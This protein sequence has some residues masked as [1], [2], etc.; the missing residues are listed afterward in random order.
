MSAVVVIQEKDKIYFGADTAISI[1]INSETF[2]LNNNGQKLFI[3]E[4]LLIFCSGNM[5]L[6]KLIIKEF[7]NNTSHTI[8][9]LRNIAK[10]LYNI[11]PK[12]K[13]E[14]NLDIIAGEVINGKSVVYQISPYYN[15]EIMKKTVTDGIGLYTG[16]IKTEDSFNQMYLN[17]IN[18]RGLIESYQDTFNKISYEGIGGK[19]LLYKIDINGISKIYENKIQEKNIKYFSVYHPNQYLIVGERIFGKIIAGVNLTIENDSGKYRFDSSGFTIDGGSITIIGGL[20]P[21]QLDPA[22]K[23]SLVELN[24]DYSNGVRIDTVQGI[25]VTR[26]DDRVKSI[27]NATDGIKIQVKEGSNWTD[28]F[29]FDATTGNLNIDG[30][31]NAR[32]L[33]VNGQSV[34]TAD[35]L[36]INGGA[37]DKIKVEQL[38][39]STAKITTAM[40]E[41]LEV[42]R[43]VVMGANATISWSQVSNKPFIPQTA[44]DVGALP[45]NSPKL[46]YIDAYG[47]YTG[48][49]QANNIVGSVF[50]VGN[51]TGQSTKLELWTGDNN[52]HYIKSTQAA[53]FR[54]EST[55]SLSLQAGNGYGIYINNAPLVA[56][57][58]LRV[59]GGTAQFNVDVTVNGSLNASTLYEYGYRVAT[60]SWVQSWVWSQG[61]LTGNGAVDS[62]NSSGAWYRWAYNTSSYYRLNSSG[63]AVVVNGSVK[64]TWTSMPK[65]RLEPAGDGIMDGREFGAN[66]PASM[67]PVLMDFF[68]NIPVN[69][70]CRINLDEKFLEFVSSYDVFISSGSNVSVKEKGLDYIILQGT[71][72]VSFFVAGIQR[73]KENIVGYNLVEVTDEEGNTSREFAERR[74][75][76]Y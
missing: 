10:S 1:K 75:D 15:F 38:D 45:A 33:K 3:I 63:A 18:N 57:S 73:G 4:N 62:G 61:F 64:A 48:T 58:G 74:I 51:G 44:S 52:A 23:D 53:G 11:F 70:E 66:N 5:E 7:N 67:Q 14:I 71:G 72:T 56:N 50:T 41:T 65:I 35:K 6:V 49:V 59:D 22:F 42:G 60:Q 39:A 21:S 32:D 29:Y 40:I 55:G 31:V 9:S 76:R 69:G 26:S 36:K 25:V 43:N 17:L 19:L 34:L 20:P 24:K 68:I 54:I 8:E 27:F 47:V 37:I 13:D 46:T 30:V 12:N 28:K 2:R 16:G